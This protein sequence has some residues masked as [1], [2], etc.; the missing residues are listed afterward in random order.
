MIVDLLNKI[1]NNWAKN[2]FVLNINFGLWQSITGSA[3]SKKSPMSSWIGQ[4]T[5]FGRTSKKI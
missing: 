3:I 2:E 4:K 5:S 1:Y